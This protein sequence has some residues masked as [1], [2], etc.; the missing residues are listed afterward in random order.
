MVQRAFMRKDDSFAV[1]K[2]FSNSFP[3]SKL[4]QSSIYQEI[5]WRKR[6]LL[7]MNLSIKWNRFRSKLKTSF[8]MVVLLSQSW[9]HISWSERRSRGTHRVHEVGSSIVGWQA[10]A[11]AGRRNALSRWTT[12]ASTLIRLMQRIQIT[13]Q[14]RGAGSKIFR[15]GSRTRIKDCH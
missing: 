6:Y 3:L 11:A 4:Y 9:I 1:H 5:I 2:G 13:D 12:V 7:M 8:K 10:G 14:Y 15:T